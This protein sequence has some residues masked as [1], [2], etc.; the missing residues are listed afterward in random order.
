MFGEMTN[1]RFFLINVTNGVYVESTNE[2][3]LEKMMFEKSSI[4]F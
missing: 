4:A 2:S 3:L 1:A